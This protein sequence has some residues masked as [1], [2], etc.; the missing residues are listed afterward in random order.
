MKIRN[1]FVSNSSSSSFMILSPK[2][3]INYNQLFDLMWNEKNTEDIQQRW[4]FKNSKYPKEDKYFVRRPLNETFEE[5]QKWATTYILNEIKKQGENNYLNILSNLESELY[6]ED[7][8]IHIDGNKFDLEEIEKN[9][10]MYKDIDNK[11]DNFD[12]NLFSDDYYEDLDNLKTK[13]EIFN[14]LRDRLDEIDGILK[15]HPNNTI[16]YSF[17][18]SDES[19]THF[20][21]L[22]HGQVFGNL[23]YYVESFH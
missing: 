22:E 11:L 14:T 23:P 4:T 8:K 6:Y 13:Y 15:N 9:I 20:E 10:K 21:I 1:G 2:K 16:F 17:I 3:I 18:F 19:G 5:Y 7:D 12:W